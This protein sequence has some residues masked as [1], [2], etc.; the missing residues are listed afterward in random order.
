M[1]GHLVLLFSNHYGAN[2]SGWWNSREHGGRL[3]IAGIG[4]HSIMPSFVVD[5]RQ[6]PDPQVTA[7]RSLEPHTI[8][9]TVL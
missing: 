5:R 9:P 2:S 7:A 6:I 8:I 1:A 3:G 4:D